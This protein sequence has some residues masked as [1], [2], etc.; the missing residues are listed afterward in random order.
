MLCPQ[1]S[2]S[3]DLD[4]SNNQL[5]LSYSETVNTLTFNASAFTLHAG[6]PVETF[7]SYTLTGGTVLTDNGPVVVVQE[8][9]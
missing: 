4:L 7:E 9:L 8:F 6:L 1:F 5:T 2:D 3:F